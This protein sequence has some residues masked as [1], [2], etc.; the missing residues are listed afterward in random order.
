MGEIGIQRV[1]V[2]GGAKLISQLSKENLID[3]KKKLDEELNQLNKEIKINN[4]KQEN[5]NEK[6]IEFATLENHNYLKKNS[7]INKIEILFKKI[8]KKND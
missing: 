1:L 2:E 4:T 5:I 8:E 7:N 3:V 6:Q